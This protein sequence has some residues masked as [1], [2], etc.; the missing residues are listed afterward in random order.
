MYEY[1]GW[2]LVGGIKCPAQRVTRTI[3]VH[4]SLIVMT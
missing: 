2:G 1:L 3:S 4:T